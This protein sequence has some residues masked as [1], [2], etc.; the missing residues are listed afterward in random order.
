[1]LTNNSLDKVLKQARSHVMKGEDTE[2]KKLYQIILQDFSREAKKIKQEITSNENINNN[3]N[4][5]ISSKEEIFQLTQ[6]YN[7]G[8]YSLL[9]EKA[10]TFTKINPQAWMIW[11]IL[12]ATYLQLKK[13]DS[14]LE[15]LSKVIEINPNYNLGFNNIG[16]ALK[17]QGKLDEAIQAFKKKYFT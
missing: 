11:N 7:E 1:M 4:L 17:E 12:G 14:A 10:L 3:N 5:D 13:S 6:L 8:K 9:I 15:A 2:A 16:V